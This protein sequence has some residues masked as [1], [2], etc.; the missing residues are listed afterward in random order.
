[1]KLNRSDNKSFT[2]QKLNLIICKHNRNYVVEFPMID[3]RSAG[4]TF[5]SH[6]SSLFGRFNL[7]LS[8]PIN[9]NGE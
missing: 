5:H 1:M 3:C 6:I 2:V 8:F 4:N 9:H 7:A